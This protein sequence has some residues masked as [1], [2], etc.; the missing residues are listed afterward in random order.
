MLDEDTGRVLTDNW[1]DYQIP[2]ALDA[3]PV[4]DCLPIDPRDTETNTTGT[5]G[6]GEPAHVPTAAAIANAIYHATGV[7]PTDTPVTPARMLALLA[8]RRA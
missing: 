6:L 2:T 4:V 5:K 1:H 3:P 8:A 7:R